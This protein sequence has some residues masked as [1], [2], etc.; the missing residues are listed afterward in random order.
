M[1]GAGGLGMVL[2]SPLGTFLAP[3]TGSGKK[4]AWVQITGHKG[5]P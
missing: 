5:V 2:V 3:D 1:Q 4:S